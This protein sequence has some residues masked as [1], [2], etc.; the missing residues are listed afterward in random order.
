LDGR[1]GKQTWSKLGDYAVDVLG[2]DA[3]ND[4]VTG[5]GDEVAIIQY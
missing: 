5:S 2:F 4:E 1:W 3:V